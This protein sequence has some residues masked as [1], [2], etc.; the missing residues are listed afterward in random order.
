MPA[1]SLKADI[2]ENRRHVRKVPIPDMPTIQCPTL[3][4]CI[5]QSFDGHEARRAQRAESQHLQFSR[6]FGRR[7]TW[8]Q[9]GVRRGKI[10][11]RL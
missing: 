4:D 6:T 2:T 7:S 9:T 3:L 1:L 10:E 5:A 11:E 8:V